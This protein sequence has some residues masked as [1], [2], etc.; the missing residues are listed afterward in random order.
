MSVIKK[1]VQDRKSKRLKQ[2][3]STSVVDL[4][5]YSSVYNGLKIT[6]SE[7]KDP[8]ESSGTIVI[9]KWVRPEWS[10]KPLVKLDFPQMGYVSYEL[11]P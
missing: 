9:A 10:D 2:S 5:G 4:R 1:T 8:S 3:K 7:C 11:S 6:A